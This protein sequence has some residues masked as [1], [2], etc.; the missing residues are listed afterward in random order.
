MSQKSR[1]ALCRDCD[2]RG[3]CSRDGHV[4]TRETTPIT[5]EDGGA[6]PYR[7]YLCGR[8]F[9][10]FRVARCEDCGGPMFR[11]HR[12]YGMPVLPGTHP[13]PCRT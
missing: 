12:R 9:Q 6:P 4:A 3:L 7:E 13:S 10:R 8:C 1:K 11:V 5:S 2:G